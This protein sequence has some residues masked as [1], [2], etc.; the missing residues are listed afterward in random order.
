[1][2]EN[3]I[4]Y[5]VAYLLGGI[6]FGLIFARI[7]G[8]VDI[9]Q[10]GSGSIGAT[11]VLRVLKQTKPQIAKKVAILTVAFDALKGI[12]PILIAKFL[13][14]S[15]DTLWAMAV[16]SVIGHCYSPFLKFEGGKGVATGAGVLAVFLPV[17]ILIAILVWFIVGKVLKISSLASLCALVCFVVSCLIIHPKI[18]DIDSY[19]PIFLIAF[20]VVYKHFPN[21][22][23]LITRQEKRVI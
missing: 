20:F 11:N 1:M 2:N 21:I 9:K 16:L 19:T 12:L 10:A 3:I 22:K 8:G 18:P 23:R 14:I 7:F 6:P 5:I 13:G 17:E 15:P 4:A